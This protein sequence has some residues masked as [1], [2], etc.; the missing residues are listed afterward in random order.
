M[1]NELVKRED[2]N[3]AIAYLLWLP[4]FFGI[5]GVHRMYSGR[6]VS[7]LV[8]MFTFGFCWLGQAI[9]LFFIPRMVE[10]H[11]EGRNVW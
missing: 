3:V 11:N 10:D 6:W 1:S 9:D 8:W 4:A 5:F 2:R 7:G